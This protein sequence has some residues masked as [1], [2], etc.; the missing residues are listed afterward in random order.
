MQSPRLNRARGPRHSISVLC[1]TGQKCVAPRPDRGKGILENI[2]AVRGNSND[3]VT[4]P[5]S[6]HRTVR[7]KGS[8]HFPVPR[9]LREQYPVPRGT[10]HP[11]PVV[12]FLTIDTSG[13]T[14]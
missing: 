8:A 10:V 12:Y 5:I 1:F 2:T 6:Q 9:S 11:F 3:A 7:G 4:K 13:S 14:A